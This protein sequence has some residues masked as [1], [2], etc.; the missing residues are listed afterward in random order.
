MMLEELQKVIKP[1]Y[2]VFENH[3][4]SSI[5]HCE[6]STLRLHF[7]NA[8]LPQ[9]SGFQIHTRSNG[10]FLVFLIKFWRLFLQIFAKIGRHDD[11]SNNVG[12]AWGKTVCNPSDNL[13]WL[14]KLDIIWEWSMTMNLTIRPKDVINRGS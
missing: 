2:T 11:K 4:K 13:E 3:R 10:P 8:V 12:L 9:V 5:Q 6:R 14:M 1:M 7:G